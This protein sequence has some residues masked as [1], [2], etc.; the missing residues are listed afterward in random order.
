M[1]WLRLS[2]LM[3]VSLDYGWSCVLKV[4]RLFSTDRRGKAMKRGAWVLRPSGP[5]QR[6]VIHT[7]GTHPHR[8]WSQEVFFFCGKLFSSNEIT[9]CLR[10]IWVDHRE[11]SAQ[12]RVKAIVSKESSGFK[13]LND[14]RRI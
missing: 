2:V 7:A 10:E 5:S 8:I 1:T 3:V 4:N 9:A 11:R 13:V 12:W 14:S 6:Q